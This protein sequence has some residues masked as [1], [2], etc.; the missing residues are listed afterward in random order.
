MD[1]YINRIIDEEIKNNLDVFGAVLVEGMKYC[2]KST[3]C[4]KL[5]KTIIEF[6]DTKMGNTYKS[7]VQTDPDYYFSKEPPILFDEWQEVPAVWDMIRHDI[8]R[9]GVNGKYLLT[10]SSA[11]KEGETK[12]SGIG[13]INKVKMTTLTLYETGD[14]TGEVSLKAIFDNEKTSIR[15]ESNTGL[16]QIANI[17]IRG[18]FPKNLNLTEPQVKIT[19]KGYINLLVN[20]DIKKVDGVSRDPDKVLSLLKSYA[21]NI[22]TTATDATIK[23]DMENEGI[24]IDDKTFLDYVNTLKKLFIIDN[25]KAWSPKIRSKTAIRTADR[26]ELA[27][28]GIASSVLGLTSEALINDGRT[29]GFFFEALCIH[30]LKVYVNNLGGSLFHYRDKNDFEIDAIIKLD[31]DRWGAIEIKLGIDKVDEAAENLLLFKDLVV[32]R[33]EPSFLMVLY[34]GKT[35]YKREDGVLVVPITCLRD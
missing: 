7:N 12:H 16:K 26:K 1:K 22:S 24:K 6:Q 28:T 8:D 33:K 10:G 5:A 19:N 25:V 31:D 2:G 27:D 29:F 18:G 4:K 21:R 30:D 14:S 32:A 35:A 3:T 23:K 9:T 34:G 17:I 20:E 13:R 11:P 15:G